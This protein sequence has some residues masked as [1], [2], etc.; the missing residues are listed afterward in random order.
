[1]ASRSSEGWSPFFLAYES[2]GRT[3]MRTP[4]QMY[5]NYEKAALLVAV[6]TNANKL[7]R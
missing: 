6:Y 3:K 4:A 7:R 1:M 5:K 2:N